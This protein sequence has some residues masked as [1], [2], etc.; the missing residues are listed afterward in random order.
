MDENRGLTKSTKHN[1]ESL[2]RGQLDI[3]YS[4]M[5]LRKGGAYKSDVRT[6]KE[7]LA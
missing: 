5:K 2:D 6:L 3:M 1:L 7:N 4:M